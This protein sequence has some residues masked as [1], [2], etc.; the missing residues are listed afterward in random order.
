MSSRKMK[1]NQKPYHKNQKQGS[2][3][4]QVDNS[5]EVTKIRD[6]KKL[7]AN[8]RIIFLEEQLSFQ[9]K[10]NSVLF[11]GHNQIKEAMGML[12]KDVAKV[13]DISLEMLTLVKNATGEADESTILAPK[14]VKEL[15][16]IKNKAD[17]L[18]NKYGSMTDEEMLLEME[19]K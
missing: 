15:E 16:V 8:K 4:D 7:T 10:I 1:I 6:K 13:R 11:L 9:E 2:K 5:K 3:G 19:K 14:A 17:S 12:A 18:I